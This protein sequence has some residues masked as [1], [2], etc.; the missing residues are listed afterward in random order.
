LCARKPLFGFGLGQGV[1]SVKRRLTT[2]RP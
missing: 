1:H 2:P